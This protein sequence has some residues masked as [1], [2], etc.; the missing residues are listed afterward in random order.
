MTFGAPG[1]AAGA[2]NGVQSS[3]ESRMS[4]LTT[5]FHA[6]D[7]VLSLCLPLVSDRFGRRGIEFGLRDRSRVAR[8]QHLVGPR[9]RGHVAMIGAPLAL[10]SVPAG[11]FLDEPPLPSSGTNRQSVP[12]AAGPHQLATV[13]ADHVAGHPIQ[14]R[15]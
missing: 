2:T 10:S 14:V 6:V 15:R 12:L 5:P 4:V 13:D 8:R 9:H 11:L 1:G 3:T 7:T